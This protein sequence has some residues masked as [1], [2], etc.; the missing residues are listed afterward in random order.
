MASLR[1]IFR[2]IEREGARFGLFPLM[3]EGKVSV[4]ER[5]LE[6]APHGRADRLVQPAR[7]DR[8]VCSFDETSPMD[9]WASVLARRFSRHQHDFMR[10]VKKRARRLH[11]EQQRTVE[12]MKRDIRARLFSR[13]VRQ[14]VMSLPPV[15]G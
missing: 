2:Q 1:T 15:R 11:A 12:D 4:C 5:V 7:R 6:H 8:V 9:A 10:M 3:R 13:V 14:R